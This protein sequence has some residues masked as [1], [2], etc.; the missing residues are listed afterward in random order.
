MPTIDDLIN[1]AQVTQP[2][3]PIVSGTALMAMT[4]SD[5]LWVVEGLLPVGLAILA[6]P[7]KKGKSWLG[8]ELGRA[9]CA[10]GYFLGRRVRQGRVFYAAMEDSPRRLQSRLQKQGW[11][12]S[13][14]ANVDFIFAADFHKMFVGKDASTM[15]AA[16]V[17]SSDYLLVVVDTASRAFP[18]KDWNDTG[19]VTSVLSPM[20]EVAASAGKLILIIDHHRKRNGFDVDPIADILGS[21]SKAGV[22]DTIWGL[23]RETGKPGAKL[24]V[25]GRDVDEQTLELR[26]DPT[27]GC[28]MEVSPQDTLTHQQRQTIRLLKELDG[29]TLSEL[30]NATGRNKGTLHHELVAL[31][32]KGLIYKIGNIWRVFE[33]L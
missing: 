4:F 29:A 7:P 19:L 5:P 20:Q 24:A 8:L 9:V 1:D 28:W 22:S 3:P 13:E 31:E 27:A 18:I 25:V 17:E 30:V 6:G 16:F 14:L 23:Y 10:G 15:F 2:K 21:T 32:S 11:S 26:F 12:A 33:T